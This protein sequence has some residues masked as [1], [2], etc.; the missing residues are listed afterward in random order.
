MNIKSFHVTMNILT[1]S[2]RDRFIRTLFNAIKRLAR[3]ENDLAKK[4]MLALSLKWFDRVV[5]FLYIGSTA[6]YFPVRF[7]EFGQGE[8]RCM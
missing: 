5:A 2:A 1:E 7:H 6:R 4:I 3:I 8:Q